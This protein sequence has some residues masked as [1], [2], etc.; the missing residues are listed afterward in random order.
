MIVLLMGTWC[1]VSGSSVVFVESV[2]IDLLIRT[3]HLSW[4]V[5][6]TTEQQGE[7]RKCATIS[8]DYG[9]A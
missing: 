6:L 4:I 9:M 3:D 5:S 1:H 2:T 8:K 7:Y